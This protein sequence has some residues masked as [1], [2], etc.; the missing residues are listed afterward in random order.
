MK[1]E[2]DIL[3]KQYDTTINQANSW[4]F[5]LNLADYVKFVNGTYPFKEIVALLK[6]QKEDLLIEL[7]KWEE[8]AVSELMS[9]KKNLEKL[10]GKVDGLKEKLTKTGFFSDGFTSIDR[11]LEG[12]L[13]TGGTKSDVINRFLHDVAWDISINGHS[14]LL[15]EWAVDTKS[16]HRVVYFSEALKKRQELT[17]K[18]NAQRLLN[19]WGYWDF[20]SILADMAVFVGSDWTSQFPQVDQAYLLEYASIKIEIEENKPAKDTYSRPQRQSKVTTYKHYLERIHLYLLKK[21]F[22]VFAEEKKGGF[23]TEMLKDTQPIELIFNKT[24]C[25]LSNSLGEKTPKISGQPLKLLKCFLK[26]ESNKR[27]KVE[28]IKEM[29]GEHKHSGA[30]NQLRSLLHGVADIESIP[31][32]EDKRR[33]DFY[34]LIGVTH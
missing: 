10:V 16:K 12:T 18:L 2:Q 21:E 26:N 8:K 13:N 15:D 19:L 30:R 28:V 7:D 20:M 4:Y 25:I 9:S 11:Y 14:K 29:G 32:K 33:V 3:Q 5:F 17:D 22:E 31:N 23:Y 34:H 1:N 27:K 24:T 6:Q